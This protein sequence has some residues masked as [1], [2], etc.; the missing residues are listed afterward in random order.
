MIRPPC[1]DGPELSGH[2]T[3]KPFQLNGVTYNLRPGYVAVEHLDVLSFPRIGYWIVPEPLLRTFG[4]R[5]IGLRLLLS[6]PE[7]LRQVRAD[8]RRL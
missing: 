7:A 2:A 8:Y 6:V 1:H 5:E 3:R 4:A